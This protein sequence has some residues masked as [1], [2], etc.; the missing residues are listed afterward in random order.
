MATLSG[1]SIDSTYQALLKTN[2]NG[3]IGATEKVITDGAGAATTLSLGTGS[4]S[5]T[6]NLDLSGATVTGLPSS[7]GGPQMTSTARGINIGQF[8]LI[9]YKLNYGST[10]YATG[11]STLGAG[12]LHITPISL[13]PGAQFTEVATEIAT[14]G[15][16]LVNLV[17]YGS[18]LSA[19]NQIQ[20]GELIYDFGTVDASTTG[21]KAITGSYTADATKAV[22]GCYFIGWYPSVNV[23]V[24]NIGSTA[25]FNQNQWAA[26]GVTQYRSCRL[27]KTFA[28]LP[29]DLSA[30]TTSW[31]SP[32]D[33]P[34]IGVR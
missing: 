6:G 19:S 33:F 21:I 32:N 18:V 3:A 14:S 15:A 10:S 12:F 22:D 31:T 23:G 17:L 25:M 5:F 13:A 30:E 26:F 34:L 16:G 9:Y 29:A 4:A 7:G 20:P 11:T 1:N 28:S 8:S 2:D 24:R 27:Y